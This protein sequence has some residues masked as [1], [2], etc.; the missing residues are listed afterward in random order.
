MVQWMD[1]FEAFLAEAQC[2]KR[3]YVPSLEE[4]LSN[5]V[6]TGGTYMALVHAFFLMGQGVKRENMVMLEPYPNIFS[7][8][9]KILRLWDDLGTARVCH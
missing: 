7:C 9:G 1:I 2:F 8:S 6:T 4:Y 3:G 5:A